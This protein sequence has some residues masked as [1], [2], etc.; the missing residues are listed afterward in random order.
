MGFAVF[1]MGKIFTHHKR[2]S[3]WAR[4]VGEGLRGAKEV[5]SVGKVDLIDKKDLPMT[6]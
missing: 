2:C 6:P 5:F 4:R 1:T 3:L